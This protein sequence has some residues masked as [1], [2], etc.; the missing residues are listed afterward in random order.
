M[1]VWLYTQLQPRLNSSNDKINNQI[2]DN[3]SKAWKHVADSN[4]TQ[5]IS[6]YNECLVLFNVLSSPHHHM[7]CSSW[8]VIYCMWLLV[9][10]LLYVVVGMSLC[11][12]SSE[13]NIGH[14]RKG[15]KSRHRDKQKCQISRQK[16][17]I[18]WQ[19]R[20]ESF[21]MSRWKLQTCLVPIA[22][23]LFPVKF[24]Y[25]NWSRAPGLASSVVTG[26]HWIWHWQ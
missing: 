18:S 15:E 2:K 7:V 25:S 26:E 10:D 19:C 6:N 3:L 9:C 24:C 4:Y 11:K 21:E 20:G 8:Y 5:A 12:W 17:E 16:L 1:E 14:G 23:T 22:T 13:A